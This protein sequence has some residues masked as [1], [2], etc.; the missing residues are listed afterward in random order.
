MSQVFDWYERD[1]GGKKAVFNFIEKH[2]DSDWKRE[3]LTENLDKVKVEYLFYDW[4]LNH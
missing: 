3:F 2:V 4:N 1:F